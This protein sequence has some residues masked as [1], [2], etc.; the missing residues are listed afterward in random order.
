MN[1]Y[2]T[3][4]LNFPRWTIIFTGL[5]LIFGGFYF[6]NVSA[7]TDT[8]E[9]PAE[10]NLVNGRLAF[11]RRNAGPTVPEG[12]IITSNPDGSGQTGLPISI[13]L[14]PTE[15]AWSPDGTKLA[16]A[17]TQQTFDRNLVSAANHVGIRR[18]SVGHKR[19]CSHRKRFSALT[20][21]TN[22]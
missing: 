14:V 18:G 1:R 2:G 5:L 3:D 13:T 12:R 4:I 8:E 19:R 6:F 16:Y 17:I 20:C 22:L 15:P 10:Q 7:Q 9:K 11:S 21:G